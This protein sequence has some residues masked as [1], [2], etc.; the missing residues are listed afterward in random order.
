[1]WCICGVKNPQIYVTNQCIRTKISNKNIFM[2]IQCLQL[3]TMPHGHLHAFWG[4]QF[5]V[6]LTEY[7]FETNCHFVMNFS[8]WLCWNMGRHFYGDPIISLTVK[9]LIVWLAYYF[10]VELSKVW[11]ATWHNHT[12]YSFSTLIKTTNLIQFA[13][14][15]A[16]NFS[17]GT[18]GNPCPV[19]KGNVE[20]SFLSRPSSFVHLSLM[21]VFFFEVKRCSS[22][23]GHLP[24]LVEL[25]A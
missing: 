25:A 24:L 2:V 21:A 18:W 16:V 10:L 20:W 6:K 5:V 19:Q 4:G 9:L 11:S 14:V 23:G 13:A 22:A 7:D 12:V 17:L 8:L 3:F 1:M 15:S